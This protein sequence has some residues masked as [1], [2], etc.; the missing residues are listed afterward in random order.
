[1]YKKRLIDLQWRSMREYLIFKG[2]KEP[3]LQ[4]SEYCNGVWLFLVVLSRFMTR[5]VHQGLQLVY[6]LM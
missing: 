1:M 3:N 4:E 5:Y 6:F 2:I